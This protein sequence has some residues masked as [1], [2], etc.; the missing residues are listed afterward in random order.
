MGLK[1]TDR[2]TGSETDREAQGWTGRHR[3]RQAGTETDR[4][5]NGVKVTDAPCLVNWIR[6]KHCQ[7]FSDVNELIHV[8]PYIA[9]MSFL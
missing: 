3:D 6:N 1:L 4:K 2:Q 8:L 5:T 9:L 7:H